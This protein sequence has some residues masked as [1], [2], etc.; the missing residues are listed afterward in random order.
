MRGFITSTSWEFDDTVSGFV[1]KN[2]LN[3][4][5][6]DNIFLVRLSPIVP[7]ALLSPLVV[8]L[9]CLQLNTSIM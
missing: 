7:K 8:S 2:L 5:S 4:F 3:D 6:C 1:K 9:L